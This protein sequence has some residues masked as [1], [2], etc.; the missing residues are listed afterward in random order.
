MRYNFLVHDYTEI[1]RACRL[2]RIN[3]Q[4][5]R[6]S[7]GVCEDGTLPMEWKEIAIFVSS[8]VTVWRTPELAGN[9]KS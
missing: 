4:H 2:R 8:R 7:R 1:Y 9:N 3:P 6:H 5:M